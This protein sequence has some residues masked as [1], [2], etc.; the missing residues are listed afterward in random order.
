MT[1]QEIR[2]D[3]LARIGPDHEIQNSEVNRFINEGYHKV[4][5]KIVDD[6]QDY[7]GTTETIATVVGTQE[8]TPTNEFLTVRFIDYNP[9]HLTPSTY[10]YVRMKPLNISELESMQNNDETRF[11]DTNPYYYFWGAKIGVL[12]IPTYVGSIVIHGIVKPTDL[13]ANSDVPAFLSTHHDLL[14]TWG[15]KCMVEAVDENYLDG[16]RKQAEFETGCDELLRLIGARQ[17]DTTKKITV[18]PLY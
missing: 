9:G 8:Y 10:P 16:Q 2:N 13:S 7:F 1:L 5:A 4:I 12:P 17:S 3:I 6:F 15:M 18:T 11:A 14:V